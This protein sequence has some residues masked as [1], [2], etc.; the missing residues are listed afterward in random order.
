MPRPEWQPFYN[1]KAWKKARR[2][3]LDHEPLCRDCRKLGWLVPAT[4]VDHIEQIEDG[5]ALLD[6][7]NLQSLCHSHHSEK[8]TRDRLGRTHSTAVGADGFPLDEA[9]PF[10]G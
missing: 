7:A 6:P 2:A 5:G 1:S 10:N 4:D 3:Q 9:H 8:T